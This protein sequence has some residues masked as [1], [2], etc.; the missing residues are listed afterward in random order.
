MHGRA[1]PFRLSKIVFGSLHGFLLDRK[2]ALVGPQDRSPRYVQ[3]QTVNS[4]GPKG[5]IW[6]SAATVRTGLC[7]EVRGR[8][9]HLESAI[10]QR[11]LDANSEQKRVARLRIKNVF[12]HHPVWLALGSG[13]GGPTNETVDCVAV[14]RLVQWELV[15]TPVELIAPILQPVRPRDQHLTSAR[16][17]HLIGV[18]SVEKLTAANRV[19][20]ESS[21]NP[22]DDSLL[23][24][25]CD[26][27]LLAGWCDHL[28]AFT[29]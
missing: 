21:A 20:A 23:I 6:M 26:R 1:D 7:A 8:C 9:P 24:F 12:H 17:T 14:L 25:G 18:I 10:R 11:V 5:Q 16:R 29:G 27:D 15:T 3:N 2:A 19:R 13:P 4:F 28:F 22:D